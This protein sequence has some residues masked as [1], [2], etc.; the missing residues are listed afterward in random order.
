MAIEEL[1]LIAGPL[2][3]GPGLSRQM[4]ALREAGANLI[5]GRGGELRDL[6]EA[7]REAGIPVGAEIH[8]VRTLPDFL[9]LALILVS[10]T[11]MQD[12][13]LLTE[14]GKYDIPVLLRRG[15]ASTL[16]ELLQAAQVLKTPILCESGIRGTE[17]LLDLSAVAA[18]HRLCSFPVAVEP[19]KWGEALALGA[20]AAGADLIILPPEGFPETARTLRKLWAALK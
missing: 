2:E 14:L 10:S 5:W 12:P 11:R 15:K 20:V 1:T 16:E 7:G 13:V 18:L 4:A 8:D 19:G 9:G 6:V 3:I 17:E